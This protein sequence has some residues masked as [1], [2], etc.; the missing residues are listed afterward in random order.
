[1]T[2]KPRALMQRFMYTLPITDLIAIN[3]AVLM[4]QARRSHEVARLTILQNI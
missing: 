4:N 2:S 3:A 1:M